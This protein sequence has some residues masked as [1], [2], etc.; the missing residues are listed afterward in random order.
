MPKIQK[1]RGRPPNKRGQKRNI[2]T[3]VKTHA[4]PERKAQMKTRNKYFKK[5]KKE[6]EKNQ[7]IIEK[8]EKMIKQQKQQIKLLN[9]DNNQFQIENAGYFFVFF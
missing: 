3:I 7:K 6:N 9:K 5:Q 8:K 1:N 4:T 2:L